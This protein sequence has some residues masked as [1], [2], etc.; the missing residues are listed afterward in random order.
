[1]LAM[2]SARFRTVA[3][4]GADSFGTFVDWVVAES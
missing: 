1:M 2:R 4:P 3:R